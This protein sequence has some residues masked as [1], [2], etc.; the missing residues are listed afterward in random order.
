M[1]LDN[2]SLVKTNAPTVQALAKLMLLDCGIVELI[3][4]YVPADHASPSKADETAEERMP[5]PVPLAASLWTEAAPLREHTARNNVA[6]A[7]RSEIRR[8]AV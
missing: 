1:V 5:A 6:E 2:D 4:P 3:E 8:Y 7:Q